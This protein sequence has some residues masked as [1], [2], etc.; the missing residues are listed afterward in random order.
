LQSHRAP[1]W[2]EEGMAVLCSGEFEYQRFILLA[3]IGLSGNYIPL[4]E[5]DDGFPYNADEARTAYLESESF[6]AYLMDRLGAEKFPKFL[7][8]ISGGENFY[9]ALRETSGTGFQILEKDWEHQIRHRYGLIAV[10]GG[11]TSLWFLIT[12]LFL[13]AYMTRKRRMRERRKFAE[14][15]PEFF[16]PSSYNDEGIDEE[17]DANDDEEEI[18]WH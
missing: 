10:L 13:A 11:S 3:Q 17:E 16:P 2:F 4:E 7:D 9:Q 14:M 8:K 18:K 1:R 6:V 15:E 12:L 5:L